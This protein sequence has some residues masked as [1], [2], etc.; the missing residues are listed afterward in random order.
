MKNIKLFQQLNERA[1]T[2]WIGDTG[3]KSNSRRCLRKVLDPL[4]C[5]RCRN[6]IT[7]VQN[8]PRF[9]TAHGS[10]VAEIA[11]GGPAGT[12]PGHRG[13]SNGE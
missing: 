6:Q 3:L 12:E 4:L 10:E 8:N 9:G 2:K 7:L 11:D 13:Q 1:L 5:Y